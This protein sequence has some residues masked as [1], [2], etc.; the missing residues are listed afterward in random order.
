M[1]NSPSAKKRLRQNVKRRTR[2]RIAKKVI[3]TYSKRML[4]GITEGKLDQALADFR[5]CISRLDKAGVRRV[6]H[7]NTAARRKSKLTRDY[8]AALAA[9]KAKGGAA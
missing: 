7:P 2:N 5:F 8:Q 1:P 9:A 4:K 3:K 6:Y